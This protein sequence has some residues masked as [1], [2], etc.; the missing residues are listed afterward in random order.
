MKQEEL[1]MQM[2]R[3]LN[4]VKGKIPAKQMDKF[5]GSIQGR[6]IDK[7]I[8]TT[9]INEECDKLKIEVTK[10]EIND[11]LSEYMKRLPKGMTLET[12]LKQSGMEMMSN[13]KGGDKLRSSAKRGGKG[14]R[15]MIG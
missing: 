6:I 10:K 13:D 15:E 1:N 12:A 4:S 2:N 5:K 3:I 8:D 14:W 9:L 11:K 7:F